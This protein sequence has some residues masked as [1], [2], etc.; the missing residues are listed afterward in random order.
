MTMRDDPNAESS[1]DALTRQ[2]VRDVPPPVDLWRRIEPHLETHP[3]ESGTLEARARELPPAIAPP[4]DLWPGI[5]ARL[6][7]GGV[8]LRRRSAWL[9][10]AAASL[11]AAALF[12]LT[13]RGPDFSPA[14]G[15]ETAAERGAG[16]DLGAAA[17]MLQMREVEPDVAEAMRRNLELVQGERRAIER[18]IEM[19]P[20]DFRLRELWAYAYAT[21]LELND[22]YGRAIMSYQRGRDI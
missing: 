19:T 11:A 13:Q 14:G 2:L 9:A 17:W 15:P 3:A 21:E 10:A 8:A 12:A 6:A 1:L 4:V 16:N 18:A 5:E 20:D 7:R 22:T